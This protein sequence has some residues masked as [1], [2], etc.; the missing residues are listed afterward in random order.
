MGYYFYASHMGDGIYASECDY[1]YGELYC[2]QC[3]DSD[4]RLGYA[5]NLLEAWALLKDEVE[6]FTISLCD[7]CKYKKDCDPDVECKEGYNMGGYRLYD[8]MKMLVELY[9]ED[10]EE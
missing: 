4:M 7:N 6:T 3:G 1:D 5:E 8:V 2:E 10:Y 9:K